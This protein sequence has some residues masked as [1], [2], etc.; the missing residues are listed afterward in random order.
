MKYTILIIGSDANAYYMA[1]SYHEVY[2]KKAF[3]LA[4]QPLPYTNYSNILNIYYDDSIWEEEGFI[5]VIYKF[6]E[7]HPNNK[8]LL[9]SSNDAYAYFISKNKQKLLKDNFIFNY[10]D[11]DIIKSLTMKEEFYKKYQNS[12]IDL[13]L[14]YYFD[15]SKEKKFNKKMNY[16]VIL[17][18]SNV[19]MYNHLSFEG[20]NKI[21]K[22]ESKKEL[23][24]VI[25]KIIK[26]GYTDT[27]IIQDFIPGD[28]SYLF[29]AVLYADKNKKVKLM[30]L[31]QI[32]LQEHS[33]NMVGNAAVLINGY[34][35]Y[36]DPKE[37]EEKM[38]TFLED[39]GYQGFAEFDLKYDYRDNKFKV[40]EIN[41][42]QG[43]CSYYITPLGYNLVKVLIDD[44]I[45][46]KEFKYKFLDGKVLLSFVP[47]GVAKKYIVNEE[48]KKEVLKLWDKNVVNPIKYKKDHNFKRHLYL[49][50]KHFRYYKEY[51]NG[52]WKV[53]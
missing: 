27:L 22:I 17:K 18:P 15:C 1:R 46:N 53:S 42:R 33:K 47:K 45:Y 14:T 19:I 26:S 37:V 7:K 16:P 21:Y 12:V 25:S 28:D 5:N 49:T 23:D 20:K 34:Y 9:I 31:A 35:Q 32:G 24:E 4:K 13:P 36:G 2:H 3:V 40:L 48:Y 38:K 52:Y 8:I 11:I 41:A 43:R 51:K 39:I 10:P 44:L 50:K 29:D 30:S 6:K